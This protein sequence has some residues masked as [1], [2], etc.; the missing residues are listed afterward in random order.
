MYVCLP[1]LSVGEGL[2]QCVCVRACACSSILSIT[3][4]VFPAVFQLNLGWTDFSE[5]YSNTER[6]V[7]SGFYRLDTLSVT[8]PTLS[9]HCRKRKELTLTQIITYCTHSFFIRCQTPKGTD[10]GYPALV[11]CSMS[12][13]QDDRKRFHINFK[14]SGNFSYLRMQKF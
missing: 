1:M 9:K 10:A 12:A 7:T 8:E 11:L 13:P 3:T 2:K 4:A 6:V 5:T 14:I